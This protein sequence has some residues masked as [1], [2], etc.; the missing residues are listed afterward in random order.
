LNYKPAKK[1]DALRVSQSISKNMLKDMKEGYAKDS[2]QTDINLKR[3]QE[4][5]FGDNHEEP[6]RTK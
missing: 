2:D 6:A 4:I 3:D 5:H 1:V